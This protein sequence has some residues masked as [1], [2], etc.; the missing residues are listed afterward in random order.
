MDMMDN[1]IQ[2]KPNQF[3]FGQSTT[4]TTTSNQGYNFNSG[5]GMNFNFNSPISSTNPPLFS[6]NTNAPDISKRVIRKATRR[7]KT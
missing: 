6:G 4:A 5:Q 1:N 2:Q 7:K 3:Q